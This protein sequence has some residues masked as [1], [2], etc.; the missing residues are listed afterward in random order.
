MTD[1]QG[2]WHAPVMVFRET[3]GDTGQQAIENRGFAFP[4]AP[5]CMPDHTRIMLRAVRARPPQEL[6]TC[7]PLSL[8]S[9]S[10]RRAKGKAK[11]GA[12][13]AMTSDR[14]LHHARPHQEHP[15]NYFPLTK[16]QQD[17]QER[18]ADLAAREIGPHAAAC[19]AQGAF[20]QTSLD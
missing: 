18:V 11:A 3:P 1:P 4:A 8:E 17:W 15:M 2:P 14:M 10:Q 16:A 6:A 19:D 20:P 12:E 5:S 13:V 9:A 7:A